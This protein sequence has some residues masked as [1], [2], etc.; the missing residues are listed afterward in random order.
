MGD[1]Y[2]RL[3][4]R[5]CQRGLGGGGVEHRE[6]LCFELHADEFRRLFVVLHD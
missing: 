5:E 1:Q 2:Q 4:H 6:T 3:L